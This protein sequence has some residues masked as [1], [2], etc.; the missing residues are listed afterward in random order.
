MM[1]SATG[2]WVA[3][4]HSKRAQAD[5]VLAH[6]RLHGAG[7]PRG[8]H[9]GKYPSPPN[10]VS[11]DTVVAIVDYVVVVIVTA[12]VIVATGAAAFVVAVVVIVVADPT[13]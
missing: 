10:L 7:G 5:E 13:D 6:R 11:F 8:R 12:D 2:L 1:Y 3:G 9:P 4:G